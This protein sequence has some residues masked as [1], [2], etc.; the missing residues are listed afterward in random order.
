MLLSVSLCNKSLYL[1]ISHCSLS[2][3]LYTHLTPIYFPPFGK[4]VNSQVFFSPKNQENNLEFN[5]HFQYECLK[6]NRASKDG[7]KIKAHFVETREEMQDMLLMTC[8]DV[9]KAADEIAWFL[10]YG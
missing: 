7:R 8:I 10:D 6:K 4:S 9:D 2:F 3:V 1:S 5:D